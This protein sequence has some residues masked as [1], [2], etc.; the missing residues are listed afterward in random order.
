MAHI[1]ICTAC[2]R[3]FLA[4]TVHWPA[5]TNFHLWAVEAVFVEKEAQAVI[6]AKQNKKTTSLHTD[7]FKI[8]F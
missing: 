7:K 4:G 8:K 2:I 6:Q 1:G 3:H 5:L